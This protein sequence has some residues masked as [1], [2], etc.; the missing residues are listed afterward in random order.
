MFKCKGLPARQNS[1]LRMPVKLVY[2]SFRWYFLPFP[3]DGVGIIFQG[4]FPSSQGTGNMP[5][6]TNVRVYPKAI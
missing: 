1:R 2:I 5:S 4:L 3:W 6:L